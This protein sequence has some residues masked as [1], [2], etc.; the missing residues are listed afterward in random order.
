M[1]Q[2]GIYS[3]VCEAGSCFSQFHVLTVEKLRVLSKGRREVQEEEGGEEGEQRAGQGQHWKTV[4]GT[5]GPLSYLAGPLRMKYLN[6]H[7][8]ATTAR[9]SMSCPFRPRKKWPLP[10]INQHNEKSKTACISSQSHR[11]PRLAC[12]GCGQ[13][14]NAPSLIG[15]IP[16]RLT[17][18]QTFFKPQRPHPQKGP[19]S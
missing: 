9:L 15:L 2:L 4:W 18:F 3:L 17:Q 5:M 8:S 11:S 10:A 19:P 1:S 14:P 13:D 6:Y 12:S 16:G 7:P